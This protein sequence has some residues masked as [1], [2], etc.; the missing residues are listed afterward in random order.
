R[1]PRGTSPRGCGRAG[2]GRGW[3][4]RPDGSGRA[5]P[6]GQFGVRRRV[7]HMGHVG[8]MRGPACAD[9]EGEMDAE[10][11]VLVV[12]DRPRFAQELARV[13]RSGSTISLIGLVPDAAGVASLQASTKV[14]VV[15]VDL[16]R[17][18]EQG[19]ITLIGVC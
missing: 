1:P 10:I 11:H 4:V 2:A 13:L 18:D 8:L 19:L 16:D 12:G 14:N 3:S 9:G 17:A 7:P 5:R 6:S 15:I